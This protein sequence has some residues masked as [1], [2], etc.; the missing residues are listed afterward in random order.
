MLEAYFDES[1][2]HSESPIICMAG[3][4]STTEQWNH[5]SRNWQERL[6]KEGIHCF[7]MTDF[8]NRRGPFKEMGKSQGN[9]LIESLIRIIKIRVKYLFAIAFSK[10]DFEEVV[11]DNYLRAVGTEWTFCAMTCMALLRDWADKRAE[12]DPIAFYFEQGARHSN[13]LKAAHTKAQ[14]DKEF[15][16]RM[17]LGTFTLGDRRHLQPL[18]AAD[19]LAYEAYKHRYNKLKR[20]E[21]P[22]RKSLEA[23]LDIPHTDFFAEKKT[24]EFFTSF[25]RKDSDYP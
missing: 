18:Q 23:L 9:L 14:K 19:I 20:P 16:S 11:G 12:K 17:N 5:F 13:A 1:G 10:T 7:H 25:I 3:F 8:E 4:I 2:T 6:D 21:L 24:L 15:V 22:M